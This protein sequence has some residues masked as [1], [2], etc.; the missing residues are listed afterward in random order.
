MNIAICDDDMQCSGILNIM[1]NEYAKQ[2]NLKDFTVYIYN[3]ADDLIDAVQDDEHFDI[4]VDS[5][6]KTDK[7]FHFAS[8]SEA[9]DAARV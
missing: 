4:F 7:C 1:L 8:F 6:N 3:H 2:H 5:V 9:A